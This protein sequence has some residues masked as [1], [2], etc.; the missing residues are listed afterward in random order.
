[1][2]CTASASRVLLRAIQ[3]RKSSTFYR[4][5]VNHCEREHSGP[6]LNSSWFL[7]LPF[8]GPMSGPDRPIKNFLPEFFGELK[9]AF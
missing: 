3:S 2:L 8:F 7:Y 5:S 9:T 6:K 1:M 4:V